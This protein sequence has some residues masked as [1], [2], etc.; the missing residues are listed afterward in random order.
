MK[1]EIKFAFDSDKIPP[2]AFKNLMRTPGSYETL[3]NTIALIR[4][5]LNGAACP[6]HQEAPHITV[7]VSE[8]GKVAV[9][10]SGCCERFIET[11]RAPFE[12]ELKQ[13]AY[14]TPNM[15]VIFEIEGAFEPLI[16]QAHEIV[17]MTLG[18]FD[19]GDKNGKPDINLRDY[20]AADKGVSRRHAILFW[21]NGALNIVDN[22]SSNGTFLNDRALEPH[23]PHVLHDCDRISLA[24]LNM[25]VKL[26]KPVEE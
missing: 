19:D 23:V 2:K 5:E 20:N 15:E 12:R 18:R 22:E 1:M 14:F 9:E 21:Q 3:K 8:N 10:I 26:R 25:V 13:T 24:G 16:F 7:S 4:R 11:V 6:E 17:R